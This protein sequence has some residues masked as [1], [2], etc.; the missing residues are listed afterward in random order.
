[1]LE[2]KTKVD[3]LAK[4]LSQ[5]FPYNL[6]SHL[7]KLNINDHPDFIFDLNV[8]DFVKA[9]DVLSPQYKEVLILHYQ[10][11]LK[12]DEIAGQISNGNRQGNISADK[13]WELIGQAESELVKSSLADKFFF[14]R[15]ISRLKGI[16][17]DQKDKLIDQHE[18]LHKKAD[19]FTNMKN[20]LQYRI[21]PLSEDNFGIDEFKDTFSQPLA[22]IGLSTRVFNIL[23]RPGH[24][25]VGDILLR[26]IEEKY[27]SD[28]PLMA[29]LLSFNNMGTKLAQEAYSKILSLGVYTPGNGKSDATPE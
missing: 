11:K 5:T 8:A 2:W 15:Y 17:A 18:Q 29:Y 10:S 6:Y 7:Y 13:V 23:K 21:A 1:M 20:V 24:K 14:S 12:P 4:E 22:E 26:A 27:S 19:M 25:T 16:I 3:E 28:D 9:F